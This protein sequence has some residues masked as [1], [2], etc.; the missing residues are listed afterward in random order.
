MP[1]IRHLA[2]RLEGTTIPGG[3]FKDDTQA[4]LK[5]PREA[6]VALD[7]LGEFHYASGLRVNLAKF[8]ALAIGK[9]DPHTNQLPL[10]A[11]AHT[12]ILGV[13]FSPNIACLATLN[14]PSIVNA[15][16]TRTIEQGRLCSP[17]NMKCSDVRL[18]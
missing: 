10:P 15:Q 12:R 11:V 13:E 1:L 16:P 8:K 17:C 18:T 9:W 14:W 4:L 5:S 2:E 3:R 6:V 7:T